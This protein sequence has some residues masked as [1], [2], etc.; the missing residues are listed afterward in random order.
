MNDS[1]RRSSNEV[2]GIGNRSLLLPALLFLS[3][4][5]AA[6]TPQN[7][8]LMKYACGPANR[9]FA[10]L[11][12][13]TRFTGDNAGFDLVDSP[14][15]ANGSCTSDKPF[16]FSVAVPEGSYHVVVTLGGPQSSVTTV[17]AEGRRLMLE[18]IATEPNALRHPHLRRQRPL[19]R[20]QR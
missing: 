16:F 3:T 7:P 5:L 8:N 20:N 1:V 17:R 12:P 19:S 15:V 2:R 11:S 9:L 6:Q 14:S 18:K 13:T 4:T 10:A